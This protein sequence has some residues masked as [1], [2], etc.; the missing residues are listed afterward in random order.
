MTSYGDR[1]FYGVTADRDSI[2]DTRA[3][4]AAIDREVAVLTRL[5]RGQLEKT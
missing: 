3:V 5:A 1:L 2:P 4:S